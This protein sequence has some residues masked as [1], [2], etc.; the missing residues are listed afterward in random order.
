MRLNRRKQNPEKSVFAGIISKQDCQVSEKK[1]IIEARI[2]L[3]AGSAQL[4][5]HPRFPPVAFPF[6]NRDVINRKVF[7]KG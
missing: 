1:Q 5:D 6:K 2:S 7:Y 4:E 3:T